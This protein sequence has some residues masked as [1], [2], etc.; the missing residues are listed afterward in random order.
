MVNSDIEFAVMSASRG[1]M[2]GITAASA[3]PN[4]CPTAEKMNVIRS[5]W[6]KSF[7]TPGMRDAIGISA[8]AAARPT[9]DHSM[10]CLRFRRSAMTPAR[11]VDADGVQPPPRFRPGYARDARERSAELLAPE[12][13]HR[14]DQTQEVADVGHIHRG[15]LADV[16]HD[17][18]RVDARRRKERRRRDGHDHS[19]M[20]EDLHRDGA[21]ASG[22]R[23]RP[24]LGDRLP[25][26]ERKPAGP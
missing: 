7:W 24:P 15:A 9:F 25:D 12:L 4:S 19:R 6:R 1:R 10:I 2:V 8:T 17:E 16:E 21:E 14:L 11:G 26:H 23:R 13:E 20:G 18:R 3:G 22:R 5:K